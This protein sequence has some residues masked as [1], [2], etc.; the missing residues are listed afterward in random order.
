M[1][2]PE[3]CVNMRITSESMRK[4]K[5]VKNRTLTFQNNK[6][7]RR[8]NATESSTSNETTALVLSGASAT[9]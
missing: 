9:I 3:C 2:S 6:N 1:P 4:L 8:N 5:R 7:K